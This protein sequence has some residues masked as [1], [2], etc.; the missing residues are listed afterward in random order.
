MYVD[1]GSGSMLLQ[2]LVASVLG[3][4][5]AFRKAV[6]GFLTRIRPGGRPPGDGKA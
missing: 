4:L 2:V 3:S 1:P 5:I 6:F